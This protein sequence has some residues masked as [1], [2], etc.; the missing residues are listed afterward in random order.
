MC[1]FRQPVV[2]TF[3]FGLAMLLLSSCRDDLFD[4]L[5]VKD[6]D[7]GDFY[8]TDIQLPDTEPQLDAG[9]VQNIDADTSLPDAADDMVDPGDLAIT[10]AMNDTVDMDGDVLVGFDV[11]QD[12]SGDIQGDVADTQV[13]VDTG[14]L[15]DSLTTDLVTEDISADVSELD[16]AEDAVEPLDTNVPEDTAE[17]I[18]TV[19]PVD[20][21]QPDDITEP[22]DVL[23]PIDVVADV[24]PPVDTQEPTDTEEPPPPSEVIVCD[25]APLPLPP[26]GQA[27]TAKAGSALLVIRG[28][29]LA[30]NAVYRGGEVVVSSGK[31]VCAE[32]D[33]SQVPGYAAATLLECGSGVVSPGLIN[34]HDHITFTQAPPA[35]HGTVR[36]DHRHEW[37]KGLNGKKKLTVPQNFYNEGET[38]GEIRMALS[39]V[40]SVNS[41]GGEEGFIRNLDKAYLLEGLSKK[42]VLYDT[43]PLGDSGGALASKG[44]GAYDIDYGQNITGELAYTPHVAEGVND[45]AY[46]EYLCLSGAQAGSVDYVKDNV[47]FIHAIGI[48]A[49]EVA[50]MTADGTGLIWS[51]RSNIDLYGH[52]ASV[53]IYDRLGALI[54]LGTDWTGSGSMNMLRELQ[55]ADELNINQYNSYFSDRQLFDMA[56]I[57]AAGVLGY[58]DVIGALT[59]GYVADIAIFKAP[60]DSDFRGVIDASVQTVALVLRSGIPLVGDSALVSVFPNTGANQCE[61]LSVCGVAKSLCTKRETGLTLA[62]HTAG[63][64][65]GPFTTYPLF[66]CGTPKDEPSCVPLRPGEYDGIPKD[67]DMDGDGVVNAVDNC[68]DVFNAPRPMDKG[69]QP[70]IDGDSLGDACDP[71]PFDADSEACTSVD[72][73]DF[74]GDL[75]PNISDNCPKNA[76]PLQQDQDKDKKGDA[77]DPCPDFPNPGSTGCPATLYD[78]NTGVVP[79]GSNV[80]VLEVIVTA[81]NA[82]GFFI[83]IP[84]DSQDYAGPEYSAMYVYNKPNPIK[85][86]QGDF[87]S[88]TGDTT[89]FFDQIQIQN[90]AIDFVAINQP[91]PDPVVVESTQVAT[92]GMLADVYENV[93]V[94][95]EN[96]MVTDINPVTSEKQPTNEFVVDDSLLIDDFFYK[97]TPTP[98]VGD[99]FASVTGVLRWSF[100]NMKLEPRSANDVVQGAP[101]LVGFSPSLVYI[102]EGT[103]GLSDPPLVVS[104]SSPAVEP[105][106]ISIE[107]ADPDVVVAQGGGV[108]IPQ[109]QMSATVNLESFGATEQPIVLIAT[110][111]TQTKTAEVRV[112]G[113]DETPSL[114]AL[115]PETQLGIAGKTATLTAVLNIPAAEGGTWIEIEYDGPPGTDGPT[116][117]LVPEGELS[118][119]FDVILPDMTADVYVLAAAGIGE[120]IAIIE[121]T[122][123]P[124]V[125]L[126]LVE[127]YFD[128]TDNDDG[129]EWVK[130]YN[131]TGASLDL[132]GYSLGWGGENYLYGTAQLSGT[133]AAGDCFVIGG[134]QKNAANGNPDYDLAYNLTPD[135]QNSGAVADGVALFNT[136]ATAIGTTTVPID[137]VLYGTTNGSNLLGPDGKPAPVSAPDTPAAQSIQRTGLT[138]WIVQPA[139]NSVACPIITVD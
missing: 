91:I 134:P 15:D 34:T 131:G 122:D 51:P 108:W 50:E 115:L 3:V 45:F 7:G 112:I 67:N 128:H 38:W 94:R 126:L 40:T 84:P 117:V 138:T 120:A 70:N 47:A 16:A 48:T 78:I 136:V 54:G 59:P 33:C 95:V 96:V 80:V 139:P 39:G 129:Y 111:G 100:A 24:V 79:T 41:S 4:P 116:E 6:P 103:L 104:L 125:G 26:N 90:A 77:C 97:I 29:I 32:C 49:V 65:N 56:T 71:C 114:V 135:L 11:D 89:V 5:Q 14:N 133:V 85:P 132:S 87:I 19:D 53:T 55:C 81:A 119:D 98:M 113:L 73:N 127:V 130:L 20:V 106:W 107:S 66:F 18:D 36:Y 28:T 35:P 86:V 9:D 62:Q 123:N 13:P 68:P 99:M 21:S 92:A 52:T 12:Q 121:V 105:V 31:I 109:G 64:S 118:A 42:N 27:C 124:P 93:L 46:N 30:P 69:L 101:G 23:V 37:R 88:L 57:N 63:V 75:V 17:P 22:S 2:P 61:P 60:A 43:F 82:E 74:D 76:N 1:S 58:D 8:V 44:C 137:A 72:P 102:L 25:K 83:Q 110:L 10:D